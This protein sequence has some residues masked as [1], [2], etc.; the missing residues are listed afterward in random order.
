MNNC[1]DRM[2]DKYV[3]KFNELPE[4]NIKIEVYHVLKTTESFGHLRTDYSHYLEDNLLNDVKEP[5][6][7]DLL[8]DANI[9]YVNNKSSFGEA[10]ISIKNGW[11]L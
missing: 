3:K 2:H 5:F 9:A 7:L 8:K 4:S 6:I 11:G 1:W 10:G